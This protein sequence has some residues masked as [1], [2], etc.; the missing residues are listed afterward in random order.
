MVWVLE[1]N[2][3]R[4]F[5]ENSGAVLTKTK[6]IEIGGAL[7]EEVALTWANLA[8]LASPT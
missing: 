1:Q 8:M 5:Y 6:H 3:A 7:L 2:P 4:H